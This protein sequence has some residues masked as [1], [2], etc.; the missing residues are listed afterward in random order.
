MIRQWAITGYHLADSNVISKWENVPTYD[1][2][3]IPGFSVTIYKQSMVA[4]GVCALNTTS[5]ISLTLL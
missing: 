3:I 5:L 1:D 4:L 2:Y